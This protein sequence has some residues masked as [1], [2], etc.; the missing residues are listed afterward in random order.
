[1]DR[2][3]PEAPSVELS[4]PGVDNS[5]L[6]DGTRPR[7]L[8]APVVN[9]VVLRVADGLETLLWRRT[10]PPAADCWSLPGGFVREGE[11]LDE[12]MRRHLLAKVGV[13]RVGHLE[14]LDSTAAGTHP[15]L[16]LLDVAHLALVPRGC[17]AELPPDTEWHPVDA[18]PPIAFGHAA[19]VRRAHERLKGKL[20]YSNAAFALAPEAFTLR[21]LAAVY[22]AVL[23]YAVDATNLRR[24]L[25]R[26]GLIAPT[27]RRRSSGGRPAEEFAFTA[28]ELV[29]SRPL[30]AFRG[31]AAARG[32][33]PARSASA[34]PAR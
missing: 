20:S 11:S 3:V 4:T 34:P 18:L 21:E 12:A 19:A 9:A 32:R 16:W 7:A 14:Q 10:R 1:M 31:P 23:G 6:G 29:V 5:T 28:R 15:E 33:A 25:E 8:A 27:G 30:A 24:V 17:E 13:T 2:K 22:E 26:D